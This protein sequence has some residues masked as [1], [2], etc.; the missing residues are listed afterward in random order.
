[1]KNTKQISRFVFCLTIYKFINY[2]TK[3]K[4]LRVQRQKLKK[5]KKFKKKFK[6]VGK[7]S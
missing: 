7:F 2:K 1:M 5:L 4:R 6:K 3:T